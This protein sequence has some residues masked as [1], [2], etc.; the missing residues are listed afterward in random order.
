MFAADDVLFQLESR[1]SP[2]QRDVRD[3]VRAWVRERVLP[4]INAAWEHAEPPLALFRELASLGI[5]GGML[6]DHGGAGLDALAW[7]LARR[8]LAAGDGSVATFYGVHSGLAMASIAAFGDLA[9][10][11][12]WL[13][14][15][16][17][18][19]RLG[20][21]ALTEPE[22]GS[23]AGSLATVATRDG[24]GWR[25]TGRKRWIGNASS[26][27]LLVVWARDDAGR[28][29]GFVIEDPRAQPGIAIADLAGKVAKRAIANA[30]VVL[31]RAYVPSTARLAGV[32][33]FADLGRVLGPARYT[34]AWEA[35][36]IAGACLDIA[37][38][39]ARTR[40]QFGK[41]IGAFQLVQAR[42]AEMAG[43]VVQAH[44]IGFELAR[45]VDAGTA[46]LA[47][48]SLAKLVA[49][50]HAREVAASARELLGADGL[51]LERHVARL[52]LDAEAALTYE[53][54]AE[55]NALVVGR[56]LTGIS[57]FA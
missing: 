2:A 26:A 10:R 55:V 22:H 42:L 11:A 45:L 35:A 54:T 17:R 43:Q 33:G 13:P 16:A 24:D 4:T 30:D 46:S 49:T 50:R 32:T 56:A 15:M 23:D 37:L 3:R 5:V 52:M 14:A 51:L 53:G 12:Q 38:A 7:G 41:P 47:A 31:D 18:C 39:H 57:A 28:F 36:G 20:A 21:F 8:E 6:R 29:C 9:Q 34:I 44:L 48:I 1:L 40:A 19:E 25:L 27:D